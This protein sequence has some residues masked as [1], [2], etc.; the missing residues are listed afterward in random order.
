VNK[1]SLEMLVL[2]LYQFSSATSLHTH[3]YPKTTLS[4]RTSGRSLKTFKQTNSLSDTGQ[5]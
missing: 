1:V 4:R 2:R 5:L 3:L